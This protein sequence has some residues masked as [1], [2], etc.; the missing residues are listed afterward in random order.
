MHFILSERTFSWILSVFLSWSSKSSVHSLCICTCNESAHGHHSRLCCGGIWAVS[1]L[2][3]NIWESCTS[4][5]LFHPCV[6]VLYTS[7]AGKDLGYGVAVQRLQQSWQ[8][9]P[10]VFISHPHTTANNLFM[11]INTTLCRLCLLLDLRTPKI[12]IC[13]F[14]SSR[15]DAWPNLQHGP[16]SS[17]VS[18]A[19]RRESCTEGKRVG[20]MLLKMA[21]IPALGCLQ[22]SAS[23]ASG[24]G[25]SAADG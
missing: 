11:H 9:N 7:D 4:W 20:W 25:T 2:L 5:S 12:H 19:E 21:L 23:R 3:R 24:M 1:Q 13:F 17:S 15:I 18:T 22:S 10:T 6:W 16:T 8:G 14:F